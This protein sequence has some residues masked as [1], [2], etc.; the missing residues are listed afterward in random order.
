VDEPSSSQVLAHETPEALCQAAE[1]LL[2]NGAALPAYDALAEGVRAFPEDLRLRQLLALALARAGAPDQASVVLQQ[3]RAAGHVDEET[4]GLLA[5]TCKDLW[6]LESSPGPRREHLARAHAAYLEAHRRSGGYWSGINVATTALL[7]GDREDAMAAARQVR[8]A[9]TELHRSDPARHDLYWILATLGEASLVL[10]DDQAAYAWYVR[11]ANVGRERLADLVSTRRNARLIL[12]HFGAET[13]ALDAC[14]AIPRVVAFAGHLIDR[15]DRARPRFPPALEA[16]VRTAVGERLARA[17]AGFG[18]SSAACGAD[19]IFLEA[20][21]EIGANSHVV[22]PFNREQFVRTSVDIVPGA[23]WAARFDR[24]LAG[25]SEVVVASDHPLG[26]G[27]ISYE[28]AFR[29]IDGSAGVRADELDTDLVCLAVWDGAPGEGRGGTA[30]AVDH[31]RGRGRTVEVV[32]LV[33]LRHEAGPAIVT[34]GAGDVGKPTPVPA[35]STAPFEPR[36]VGILFADAPGFSR[37]ND[38]ELPLF[39]DRYLGLVASELQAMER[40]PLLVNTWGDGLYLVFDRVSDAG[41]LALGLCRAIAQTD[42]QALGFS[43]AMSIRIGLHAGPA[44]ACLDP[45]TGRA[46]YI[47]AHVSRAARIEPVTPPGTAYASGAF[48]ALAKA[49]G[50]SEF[51]CS[52]VGPMTLAKGYGRFPTYLV[53]ATPPRHPDRRP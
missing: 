22:L 41:V 23:D 20:L 51:A 15:P 34:G 36:I 37:L 4:L 31:W 39:V 52:Y 48:A 24:A 43:T 14:F 13:A 11:A 27:S 38:L 29:L 26:S 50:V 35:K 47:G 44:Y 2:K 5:R 18:F 7:L 53:R 9:C 12:R 42:W 28:Y 49:E 40:P 16:A 1:T 25:A 17:S 10:R 32:D 19:L 3:L 46:N 6:A 30:M 8:D 33:A 21:A 45:I